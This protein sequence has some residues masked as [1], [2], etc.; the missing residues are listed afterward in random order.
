MWCGSVGAV[1]SHIFPD[2]TKQPIAYASRTL[3]QS[4]KGYAKLEKEAIS[5]LESRNSYMAANLLCSQ[6]INH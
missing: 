1:L 2:G 3:S 6:I 5:L 4:E